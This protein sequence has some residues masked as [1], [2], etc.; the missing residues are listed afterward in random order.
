MEE[1]WGVNHSEKDLLKWIFINFR[2]DVKLS[3]I[4]KNR[5]N[6]LFIDIMDPI[7]ERIFHGRYISGKS[8][9]RRGIPLRPKKCWGKKVKFT[10]VN[11]KKN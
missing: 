7:E 11:I 6:K 4:I 2:W 1:G 8:L 9:Y 10:P 5:S 3:Q